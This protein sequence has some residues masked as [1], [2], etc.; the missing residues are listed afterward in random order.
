MFERLHDT[1]VPHVSA[2]NFRKCPWLRFKFKEFAPKTL[3]SK[4]TIGKFP[5]KT[6]LEEKIV[7]SELGQSQPRVKIQQVSN[8][9]FFYH[10]IG[11]FLIKDKTATG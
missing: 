6:K 10:K 3:L 2:Q 8:S 11:E 4:H 9:S 5:L 7:K 1:I